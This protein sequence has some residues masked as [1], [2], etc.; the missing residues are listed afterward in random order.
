MAEKSVR[1][2]SLLR[3]RGAY[4]RPGKLSSRFCL[5]LRQEAT[6]DATQ[7]TRKTG[8]KQ[9]VCIADKALSRR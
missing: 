2:Q 5:F 6:A 1:T 7:H 9:T 3:G 4:T 8:E